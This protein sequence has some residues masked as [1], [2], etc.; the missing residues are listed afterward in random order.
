MAYCNP[1]CEGTLFQPKKG[2]SNAAIKK[3]IMRNHPTSKWTRN[4]ILKTSKSMRANI[5]GKK[6]DVLKNGFYEKLSKKTVAELKKKG[7]ISGC[8]AAVL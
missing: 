7:A 4:M 2:F 5:F 1:T 6:T 8:A 3:K